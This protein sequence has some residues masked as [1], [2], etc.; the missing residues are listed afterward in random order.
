MI[1]KIRDAGATA[2]VQRGATWSEADHYLREEVLLAGDGDGD[3]D[4]KNGVYVPPFDH[5]DVWAG[6]ATMVG[7]WQRQMGSGGGKPKLDAVVCSVGGG[8]LFAGIMTGLLSEEEEEEGGKSSR[9]RGGG[10]EDDKVLLP[11]VLAVETA[12]A[13]SLAQSL[14]AGEL[15]TLPHLTSIATSLS[16]S[17]V[18]ARA[19]SLAQLPN[20]MSVVLQDAEAAMGCWRL[21][22]E[23]RMLVE[24]ACGASVALCYGGRLRRLVPGL[25]PES[26]VVVVVCGGSN[27]TLEMLVEYRRMYGSSVEEG[28]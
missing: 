3:G 15:V 28:M 10:G 2:V 24:P 6:A 18:A 5:P 17:R 21:A 8:G 13:D 27:V 9:R 12:G 14:A 7:E 25:G 4:P 22:D 26:R 23:E 19:F 11:R 1:S 16:A 20:V